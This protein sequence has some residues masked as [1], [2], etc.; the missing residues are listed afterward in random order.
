MAPKAYF[1]VKQRGESEII[2][3]TLIAIV[4]SYDDAILLAEAK[5]TLNGYH[6]AKGPFYASTVNV[7][8]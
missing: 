8:G 4:Q 6:R 3:P 1:A 2:A 5:N 7:A